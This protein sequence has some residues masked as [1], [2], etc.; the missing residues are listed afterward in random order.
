MLPWALFG[1]TPRD[2]SG[3]LLR[4]WNFYT[5]ISTAIGL[6]PAASRQVPAD[7]AA[8]ITGVSCSLLTGGDIADNFNVTVNE[9][10]IAGLSLSLALKFDR[11]PGSAATRWSAYAPCYFVAG[12]NCDIGLAAVT[13]TN[14]SIQDAVFGMSGF[15]IPRGDATYV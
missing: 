3:E 2:M 15:L 5:T 13:L 8:I 4:A 11:S 9:P 6:S 1:L 12:P 7:R 14:A 10:G